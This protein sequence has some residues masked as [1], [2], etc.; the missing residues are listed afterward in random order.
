MEPVHGLITPVVPRQSEQDQPRGHNFQSWREHSSRVYRAVDSMLKSKYS[1]WILHI[2]E[3]MQARGV[4]E[5]AEQFAQTLESMI[6]LAALLHDVGKLSRGWQRAIGWREGTGEGFWAKSKEGVKVGELPPHAF[7]ALPALRYLFCQL[8][9]VDEQGKVDRLAELIALAAAR[10]HSLGDPDGTLQWPPFELHEGV[11]EEIRQLLQN[12]LG[13]DSEPIQALITPGLF[14]HINDA[15]TYELK[16]EKHTYVLD[17]PS[18]SEDYY[19]FYVLASRMIKV[20][21]WEAS[22]EREVELCR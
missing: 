21:D 2:A 9:V 22:G 20:G 11:L 1:A 3:Q 4:L 19:P 13:E 16:E 10:H 12:E 15:S 17:T 5:S 14:D 6:C 8:G 18:P 7:H